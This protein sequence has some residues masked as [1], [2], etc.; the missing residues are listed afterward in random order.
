MAKKNGTWKIVGIILTLIGLFAGGVAAYT[1]LG[2]T[3]A[4]E[5]TTRIAVIETKLDHLKTGQ[6][7]ILKA[8]KEK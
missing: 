1:A 5:N 4:R 8:V 3:P 2:C 7:K 6:E